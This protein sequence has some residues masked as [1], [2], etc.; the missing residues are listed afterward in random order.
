MGFFKAPYTQR[1]M[2]SDLSNAVAPQLGFLTAPL[3]SLLGQQA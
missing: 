3:Y 1:V 2:M